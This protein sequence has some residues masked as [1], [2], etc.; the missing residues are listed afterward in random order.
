MDEHLGYIAVSYRGSLLLDVLEDMPRE[1]GTRLMLLDEEGYWLHGG[2]PGRQWG[3]LSDA[4]RENTLGRDMPEV[5]REVSEAWEASGVAR[6][7]VFASTTTC[8]TDVVDNYTGPRTASGAGYWKVVC[9]RPEA[10]LRAAEEQVCRR[11]AWYA[12]PALAVAAGLSLLLGGL[13]SRSRRAEAMALKQMEANSRFVPREFL[14]LLHKDALTEV[15][16]FDHVQITMTV[17]FTD[18]RSYTKISES[19]PPQQVLA[20]LNGYYQVIDPI[21]NEEGGFVDA[22]IGDAVMALFARSPEDALRAAV[23]MRRKLATHAWSTPQGRHSGLDTGIGLHC[24]ELTL[25]TVG[26]DRRMQTTAI[27]DSVN[28]AA[29]VESAT[30]IYGV[31]IIVTDG[32]RSR[33]EHPESYR[34]RLIDRVR[35]KGK[36]EVVE[37]YEVFDADPPETARLKAEG[38][39]VFEEAMR[40]YQQGDFDRAQEAFSRCATLCP[41]DTI[42]PIYLRRCNTLRRVPPGEGWT[43]VSSL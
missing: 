28:L 7:G 29:R 10:L 36:Q 11:I 26:T 42:P 4:G 34:M 9:L 33:L 39:H 6:G 13:R 37:L 21:I 8:V 31:Q 38:L 3:F 1:P 35:L 43:G 14:G 25:G 32:V 12:L 23:R 5:W 2:P 27:G 17:L 15:S 18:I 41:E 22:F 30:K 40:H 24:G 20:F 16:I 19:M